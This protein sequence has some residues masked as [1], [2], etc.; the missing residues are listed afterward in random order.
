[1]QLAGSRDG[2]ADNQPP[3]KQPE[4]DRSEGLLSKFRDMT[5]KHCMRADNDNEESSDDENGDENEEYQPGKAKSK[6]SAASKP[7]GR[8]LEPAAKRSQAAE[9]VAPVKAAAEPGAC[10]LTLPGIV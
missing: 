7:R 4:P 1:M 8:K 5:S 2:K 3:S 6:K 10:T 9:V